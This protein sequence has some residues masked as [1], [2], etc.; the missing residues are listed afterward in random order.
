MLAIGSLIH[1]ADPVMPD[2][3]ALPEKLLTIEQIALYESQDQIVLLRLS[4][5]CF[6]ISELLGGKFLRWTLKIL[7][8]LFIPF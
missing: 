2:R 3:K 1:L 6:V 7:L 4:Y 5:E 8:G